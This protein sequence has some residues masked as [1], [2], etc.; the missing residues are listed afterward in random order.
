M[1][2]TQGPIFR[3]EFRV[4]VDRAIVTLNFSD[5]VNSLFVIKRNGSAE[6]D[7]FR[8]SSSGFHLTTHHS[9]APVRPSVPSFTDSETYVIIS[10][11]QAECPIDDL[12]SVRLVKQPELHTA[13]LT[14][15]LRRPPRIEADFR[16]MP[17]QIE[18]LGIRR[19]TELDWSPDGIEEGVSGA[20]GTMPR[21]C[22]VRTPM[23]VRRRSSP[24]L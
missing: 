2:S 12:Q 13:T 21:G 7:T 3:R 4:E 24:C 5:Q 16:R 9:T 11:L 15:T 20:P 22:R 19:A 18:G 10:V 17:D 6:H 8:N 1:G 14:V 23:K